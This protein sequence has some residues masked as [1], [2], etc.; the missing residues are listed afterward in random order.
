M[1]NSFDTESIKGI[2][3]GGRGSVV[4]VGRPIT[5]RLAVRSPIIRLVDWQL[6]GW[7]F[8]SLSRLRCPWARHCTPMLPGRCEWLPTAPVYGR[9]LHECVTLCMC[10]CV[11][12][13]QP[14]W[15]KSGGQISCV[16]M[17]AWPINLI[18][19]LT[20]R[21]LRHFKVIFVTSCQKTGWN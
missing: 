4:R 13:G 3:T 15:V 14:G 19:I 12:R 11:N 6:E 17:Y 5:W 9:C 8:T 18:L 2:M 10:M 7:Q 16:C 1:H 21:L 20:R